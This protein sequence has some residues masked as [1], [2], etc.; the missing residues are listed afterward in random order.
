MIYLDHAASFPPFWEVLDRVS[1][2]AA[3]A[4]GNPGAIHRAGAN[5]R[6]ILQESRFTLAQLTNVRPEEIFF[7]SGGTEA[8]NWAIQIA[9]AQPG[10]HHIVCSAAE[11]SSILKPLRQLE[12]KGYNVTYLRPDRDG[13]IHPEQA[14]AALRQDTAMLCV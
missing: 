11:H 8:N 6:K 9:A 5:A 14:E 12:Q 1:E 7:T 3:E 4:F 10:K 13:F 2:V